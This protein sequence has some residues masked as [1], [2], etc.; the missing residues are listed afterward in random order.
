MAK[1]YSHATYSHSSYSRSG[2]GYTKTHVSGCGSK[3][4]GSGYHYS[5]SYSSKSTAVTGTPSV[6]RSSYTSSNGTVHRSASS[7][8]ARTRSTEVLTA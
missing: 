2:S 8:Q 3:S 1:S 7:T 6:T 4:Q 5:S